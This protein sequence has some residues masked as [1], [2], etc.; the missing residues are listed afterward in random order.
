MATIVVRKG[1]R[2][3]WT[4]PKTWEGNTLPTRHDEVVV[5]IG[6]HL[7]IVLPNVAACKTLTI[8]EKH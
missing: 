1:R 2:G 5:P 6:A 8:I 4:E 3:K 7:P